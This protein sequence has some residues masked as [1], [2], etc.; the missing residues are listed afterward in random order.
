MNI[1]YVTKEETKARR[2]I[3][4]TKVTTLE[5]NIRGIPAA[6]I[7]WKEYPELYS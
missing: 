4:H 1:P 2:E 7:T 5:F 6:K 3:I